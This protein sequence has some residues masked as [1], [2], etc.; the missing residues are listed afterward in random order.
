MV[1]SPGTDPPAA[2]SPPLPDLARR[3][4]GWGGTDRSLSGRSMD[5]AL[6][7]YRI[8]AYVVGTGLAILCVVG[9]PLQYLAHNDSVVAIVG[10]IHGFAYIIYLAVG[11]DMARRVRWGLGKLIPVVLAGFVPGLA[12][13]VERLTTP[14]IQADIALIK[15][16]E[17]EWARAA[18]QHAR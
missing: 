11:Y 15:A 17:A 6:L 8:M 4:I 18:Q 13:V 7:R 9:I 1:N 16:E 12:F 2:G 10:P 5:A 3:A 14:K